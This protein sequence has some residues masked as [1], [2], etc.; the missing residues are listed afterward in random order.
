MLSSPDSYDVIVIGGGHAGTEAA[1]AAARMGRK[2]LLL[3]HN[4]ET[5]GQMSC[6]PS[7]GGIGKGHL[8]QGDRCPRRRDGDRDRRSGHPIPDPQF[9]QG[10]GRAGDPGAGR[11]GAVQAGDSPSSGKPAQP[12]AVPAGRSTTPGARWRGRSARGRGRHPDS[13]SPSRPA[14][15]VL[16]AGTFLAGLVHVG[17]A[18][19]E[20]GRAGD[21]PAKRLAARLRELGLPVGPAQD[22]DAAAPRWPHASI[23]RRP[24]AAVG[25]RS[26]TGVLVHG[27]PLACIRG[28]CPAGSPIPTSART[29]SSAGGS[30]ARRCSPASSKAWGRDIARRSRTR[31]TRFAGRTSH[32]I[33]LEPE[34]LG[35]QRNLSERDL[36]LV[37]VR[38]AAGAGPF[39]EGLRARP[40]PAARLRDR[41]RLLRSARAHA[42]RWRPRRSP[43]FS[44]PDRSTAPPGTRKRPRRACSPESTPDRCAGGEPGWCPR[45]DEAYLGVLV[46]DL[47]TR[48]VTEPYRMFTSRAE[49]RLQLREDNADLRLTET[50][51]RSARRRRPLGRLCRKRDAIARELERLSRTWVGARSRS[52]PQRGAPCSASRSSANTR[53]AEL[54]RRPA[55]A[56]AALMALRGSSRRRRPGRGGA[57]GDC[58]QVRGYIDRQRQ[59]IA[60][61][62]GPGGHWICRAGLDYRSRAR[63]FGRGAA[64]ARCPPPGDD[65]PG[66]AHLRHHAGGDL[67]A[68]RASET[69]LQGALT[70]RSERA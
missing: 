66:G 62:P 47:V 52:P 70:A 14:H 32:Q 34:G 61:A 37:A 2:T 48:G 6:N 46:D 67:A 20:A 38:R 7:I 50:G 51:R 3:T 27:E 43:A 54:L 19:Y 22:R 17:L 16:T 40:H 42:R 69:R 12:H 28:R 29:R 35:D 31:S 1:L 44:S 24:R 49:Y 21:P 64:K 11:S 25:R 9:E 63:P 39:D 55:V 65:R 56:Y 30:T 53:L 57:G 58:D 36:D 4:I 8:V 10:T 15:V 26:R 23:S 41:V 33:F 60:R 45:R 5:L 59:E 13:G 18:Q 68:P